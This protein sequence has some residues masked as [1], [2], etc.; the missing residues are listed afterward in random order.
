MNILKAIMLILIIEHWIMG[1]VQGKWVYLLVKCFKY[2][3][4]KMPVQIAYSFNNK[5]RYVS[6]CKRLSNHC[7]CYDIRKGAFL[8]YSTTHIKICT[9]ANL[10]NYQ[11]I[12]FIK[13]CE[14][15]TDCI[16]HYAIITWI[17]FKPPSNYIFIIF[18]I[19]IFFL[20][21]RRFICGLICNQFKLLY[22]E[23]N[24]KLVYCSLFIE[25]KFNFHT[26][27][28]YKC[29]SCETFYKCH[30]CVYVSISVFVIWANM[31]GS[32]QIYIEIYIKH[33]HIYMQKIFARDYR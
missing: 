27:L 12:I 31:W 29:L 30:V 33:I 17:F 25:K 2:F 1:N 19:I 28:S 21:N 9:I 20:I 5:Y 14:W 23:Y 13:C 10:K 32:N 26:L 7:G 16:L 24:L 6:K 18:I 8:T 3:V 15:I 22:F 4:W 11:I